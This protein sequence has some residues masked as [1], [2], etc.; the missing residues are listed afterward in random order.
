MLTTKQSHIVLQKEASSP[1]A[2]SLELL[3]RSTQGAGTEAETE[4]AQDLVLMRENADAHLTASI[5][6]YV[7]VTPE[8]EGSIQVV[9]PH[10][11]RCSWCRGT[12]HEALA[13]CGT[14]ATH[15]AYA[16]LAEAEDWA[17]WEAAG[18]HATQMARHSL[19]EHGVNVVYAR[20]GVIWEERPDGTVERAADVA[21]PKDPSQ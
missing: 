9:L 6:L 4:T 18:Q 11:C 16:L 10:L 17:R 12:L 19:Q 2:S 21:A 15:P 7:I 13:L 1:A 5:A 3:D 14:E 20:D 8:D